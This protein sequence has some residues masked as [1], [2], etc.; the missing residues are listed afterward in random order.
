MERDIIVQFEPTREI[1]VEYS[2]DDLVVE[3]VNYT[4]QSWDIS[5]LDQDYVMYIDNIY[6]S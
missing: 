5:S 3:F 4:F 1:I 2:Q 6:L